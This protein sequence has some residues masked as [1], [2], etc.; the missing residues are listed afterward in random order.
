MS[1][2]ILCDAFCYKNCYII[3]NFHFS[4]Y[5]FHQGKTRFKTDGLSGLDKVGFRVM[6][7]EDRPLYTRILVDVDSKTAINN[8]LKE[9][10]ATNTNK[11]P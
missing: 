7:R 9:L 2:L 11:K 3:F 6:K 5:F 1:G 4:Q 8:I 10:P